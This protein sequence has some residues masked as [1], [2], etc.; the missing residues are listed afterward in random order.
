MVITLEPDTQYGFRF[1]NVGNSNTDVHILIGWVEKFNGL[2]DIWL[3]T[4]DDSYVL[5]GGEE[6][7]MYLRPQEV[8]NATATREGCKLAV[9]RQD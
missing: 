7:S 8:I 6:V 1:D 2:N 9:M 5:S 3:G 4:V